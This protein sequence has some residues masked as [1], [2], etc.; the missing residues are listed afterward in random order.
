[1]N[2]LSGKISKIVSYEGI[3]IVSVETKSTTLK[4][5]LLDTPQSCDYLRLKQ[6][7]AVV[8]KETEVAIA[9]INLGNI[10]MANQIK[11]KIDSIEN[12]KILTKISLTCRDENIV[13]II[14]TSSSKRL[15][16]KKD[17]EV[18]ALIKANELSL[19]K[20]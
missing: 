1:M 10:S 3:S 15:K 17:L 18:I 8:F 13:S 12:G 20:T 11:C 14:T 7:I 16:L 5:V 19:A 6:S 9:L 4:A 2:K